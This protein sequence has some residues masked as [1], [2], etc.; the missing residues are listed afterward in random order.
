MRKSPRLKWL[1]LRVW[2]DAPFPAWTR[3]ALL[4]I[5]NPSFMVGAMALIQDDAGR[6]LVLEHSYRRNY[7]WG[8][9][10]G[11]LKRRESPVAGIA[12][13]V[14]EETG[15]S[16]S[17]DALLDAA[18][19]DRGQLDLLYRCS[20]TSG[21]YHPTVETIRCRWALPREMPDLLPN[22]TEMLRRNG[23]LSPTREA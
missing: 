15:L 17:V 5:L 20:I 22:Q 12:R 2:R 8:L 14:L 4:R 3:N 13:E 23:I 11:W 9:P 1:L 16:V 7:R 10:G 21:V 18:F 6:V 19:F